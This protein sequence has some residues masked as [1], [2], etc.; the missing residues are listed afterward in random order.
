MTV[1][2]LKS[3][4]H[5]GTVTDADLEYE[6]SISIDPKLYR[7]AGFFL[8]EKVDV[9]NIN[10]GARLTTYIIEGKE[11]EICLNGAAAR[12]AHR[13]DKVIIASYASMT[14]QEAENHVPNV[15]LLGAN[16]EIKGKG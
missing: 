5:R 8:H 11:G 1:E 3:K 2:L 7:A 10:N 6:G 16:N 4:L 13:G 9:L 15:V 12:L 14:P